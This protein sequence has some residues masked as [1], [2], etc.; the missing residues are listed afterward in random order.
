MTCHLA[1]HCSLVMNDPASRFP[2]QQQCAC[3]RK[4]GI[5][6]SRLLEHRSNL[7]SREHV[8]RMVRAHLF[9]RAIAHV[10]VWMAV[11]A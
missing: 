11:A 4:R 2:V 3:Q 5:G 7:Q 9:S 10:Q 6:V 8:L 1:G